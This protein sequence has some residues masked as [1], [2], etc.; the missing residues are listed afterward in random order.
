[1]LCTDAHCLLA[2]L[3]LKTLRSRSI[4]ATIGLPGTAR[5]AVFKFDST[6]RF[7][8]LPGYGHGAFASEV[9]STLRG[10]QLP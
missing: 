8:L 4:L 3:G 5:P 2:R 10:L 9:I 7:L 6:E 1:M